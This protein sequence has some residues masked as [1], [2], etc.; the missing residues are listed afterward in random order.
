MK[1]ILLALTAV[2]ACVPVWAD[3]TPLPEIQ[4]NFIYNTEKH[5]LINPRGSELV[6]C[7][8][9]LCQESTP[10]G[11][12]GAQ[13]LT[14]GPGTC[15]AV[16]YDFEPF[17]QLIV[18]FEDGS[19][20]KSNIF[21]VQDNTLITQLN[22]Y[23][24]ADRLDVQPVDTPTNEPLYKRPQMWGSLALILV[25]ELLCATAFI[26]YQQKRFT[27]L[28]GVAIANVLTTAVTWGFLVHYVA[29]SALL[30]IF[31]VL[32]EA[33]L[34]ALINRKDITLKEA[35]TLSIMMNVTS[36]TLGMILS[37]IFA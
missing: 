31:C 4:F 32:A 9:R 22:V 16:A 3:V 28:Y 8:D 26:F 5:P 33:C 2:C 30:W 29:Q 27:I 23:V 13:K 12:Y 24:E 18:A 10:L 14:C 21:S 34:I 37:F 36:Y 7:K 20:R 6:Q 15:E 1:K 35:A 17:E 25:L 19:V 11:Q